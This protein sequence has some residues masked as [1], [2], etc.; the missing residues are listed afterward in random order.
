MHEY[1]KY[2][3]VWSVLQCCLPWRCWWYLSARY[4]WYY[5]SWG[6]FGVWECCAI[7][8]HLFLST[9]SGLE[10]TCSTTT[11]FGARLV[12]KLPL[13]YD[14]LF[15]QQRNCWSLDLSR[16]MTDND[17]M[18]VGDVGKWVS[19]THTRCAEGP[20]PCRINSGNTQKFFESS[21]LE[22]EGGA[23]LGLPC[24]PSVTSSGATSVS[25]RG[26]EPWSQQL[27]FQPKDRLQINFLING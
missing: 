6:H 24:G 12:C 7:W 19:R 20:T 8:R 21:Q 10:S 11:K 17:Q 4:Y 9:K 22:R 5:W 1:R 27:P 3:M 2:F 13:K 25:P 15:A 16:L 18:Q 26:A 14:A 23:G